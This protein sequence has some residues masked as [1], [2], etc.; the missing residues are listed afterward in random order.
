MHLRKQRELAPDCRLPQY[1]TKSEFI[2]WQATTN[3]PLLILCWLNQVSC[4]AY[5]QQKVI[6]R[7]TLKL[8]SRDVTDALGGF[9]GVDKIRNTPIP[10]P[11]Y[12]LCNFLMLFFALSVPFVVS[13]YN[14]SFFTAP[15]FSFMVTLGFFAMNR[16]GNELQ[17]PFGTDPNDLDLEA[18]GHALEV[19]LFEL[20]PMLKEHYGQYR[21]WFPGHRVEEAS[22][23]PKPTKPLHRFRAAASAVATTVMIGRMGH[24]TQAADKAEEHARRGSVADDLNAMFK[25]ATGAL[26]RA[27]KRADAVEDANVESNFS[28]QVEAEKVLKD[29]E[30]EEAHRRAFI[31]SVSSRETTT[32]IS[33]DNLSPKHRSDS[34]ELVRSRASSFSNKVI[35]HAGSTVK[36]EM[37]SSPAA[38]PA[39]RSQPSRS[40]VR[41]DSLAQRGR[42]DYTSVRARMIQ[43]LPGNTNSQG[44]VS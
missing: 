34:P 17:D 26:P 18:F 13:S 9:H 6:E 40:I 10:F 38:S 11:Y 4:A 2:V 19:D 32:G 7:A 31:N 22:D 36:M 27:G 23:E 33:D 39:L 44:S 16:M 41:T 15:I 1:L 42:Y 3:R 25:H 5:R 12:Q 21:L 28:P 30:T 24:A 37:N 29:S 35:P 8:F 14:T 20:F 43:S